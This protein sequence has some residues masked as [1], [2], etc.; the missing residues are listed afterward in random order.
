MQKKFLK[1]KDFQYKSRTQYPNQL[2]KLDV[3]GDDLE[4]LKDIF[5][6]HL[7]YD[8]KDIFEEGSSEPPD[9]DLLEWKW[10][11]ASSS[12]EIECR[13][14]IKLD[15]LPDEPIGDMRGYYGC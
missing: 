6:D 1:I 4:E 11:Q 15:P 5:S 8:D 13:D 14:L 10:K 12:I 3:E 7:V 9:Y 2:V